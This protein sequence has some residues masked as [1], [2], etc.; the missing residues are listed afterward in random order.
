MKTDEYRSDQQK[1]TNQWIIVDWV[2]NDYS[3]KLLG[4][5]C[6][7]NNPQQV[8]S[9]T[10]YRGEKN[11]K[12]K[13]DRI[14]FSRVLCRPVSLRH[15]YSVA[16]GAGRSVPEPA[17]LYITAAVAQVRVLVEALWPLASGEKCVK[18][19]HNYSEVD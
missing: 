1:Q 15:D 13:T 2:I 6:L 14:L 18:Y 5:I 8:D 3:I 16:P 12:V 4:L 19:N 11:H 7:S 10:K 9:I 17:G